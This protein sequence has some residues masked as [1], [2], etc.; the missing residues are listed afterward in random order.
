MSNKTT[1][2]KTDDGTLYEESYVDNWY[3]YERGVKT[4]ATRI[5]DYVLCY[6]GNIYPRFPFRKPKI[7]WHPVSP[8]YISHLKDEVRVQVDT[9]RNVLHRTI[10]KDKEKDNG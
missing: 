6:A 5:I 9:L 8:K 7:V 1:Y 2:L 3:S 4:G 10:A